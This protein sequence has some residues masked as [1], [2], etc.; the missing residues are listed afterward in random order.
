LLTCQQKF[1]LISEKMQHNNMVLLVRKALAEK[2][3]CT[4][5]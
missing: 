1:E 3:A 4:T 2:G 5:L